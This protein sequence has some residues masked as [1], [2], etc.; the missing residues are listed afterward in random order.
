[1]TFFKD[2]VVKLRLSVTLLDA[3]RCCR[4][5]ITI[6]KYLFYL[7]S[8]KY[9]LSKEYLLEYPQGA[10]LISL[11]F[12]FENILQQ[13]TILTFFKDNVLKVRLSVTFK[14]FFAVVD[15]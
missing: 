14:T 9:K 1:M 4:H 7:F 5:V 10:A 8:Y 15:M 12:I 6:K 11:I 3:F 2:I 13:K